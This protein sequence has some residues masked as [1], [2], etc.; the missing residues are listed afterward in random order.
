[1]DSGQYP[2]PLPISRA[3]KAADSD[4]APHTP[5]LV[6]HLADAL[7]YYLGAVAVGQYSRATLTGEIEPD[8]TLNR[9]LR[10]LRRVLPGQWLLWI[11]RSL[12]ATPNAPVEGLAAWYNTRERGPVA[13]AYSTLLHTMREKLDYTGDYG[14]REQASPRDL[15]E[16]IDQFR[17]RL[18]KVGEAALS[19]EDASVL[20]GAIVSGL[21]AAIESAPLLSAYQLYAPVERKLL[22]GLKPTTPMP[23]MSFPP[24][25]E[26]LTLL[27][28]PPGDPPDYT[29][30][31][32]LDQER[33]P[34]F[35]LDPLLSYLWCAA[36]DT[37]RIFALRESQPPTFTYVGLDP[38][39]GHI[40]QGEVRRDE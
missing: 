8:P 40:S 34:L 21:R 20:S 26:I 14:D 12:E 7:T 29:K 39:C 24:F 27:L 18:G 32:K 23:P 19:P 5:H 4:A 15:L 1:M 11:A 22:M 37:H 13:E 35:P 38:D 10:N 16:L 9:S 17:I 2:Y 36:C 3:L 33:M 30:R 25:E 28:Y 31:P 6:L